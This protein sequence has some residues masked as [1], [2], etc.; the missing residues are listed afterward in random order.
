VA[1][2]AARAAGAK[3]LAHFRDGVHVETKKDGTP[4]SVAD[5]ESEATL[6]AVISKAFPS[7]AIL[8]EEEGETAGSAPY[9]WIVDPIDGTRSFVHGVPLWG[10]LVGVEV[11][12][13]PVVGVIHLPA[14][15]ETV[16]AARGE[17]CNRD[18]W[19]CHVST[20][21]RV[22]DSLIVTTS[23]RAIRRAAPHY[24][25]FAERVVSERSWG[26]CYGY[27]LVA[28]GRADIALDNRLSP[29]DLAAVLP[30]VEE[31]GGRMTDWRGERTIW[32]KEVVI[33]NG[34]LHDET[35]RCLGS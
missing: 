2:D 16:S 13:D 6:R 15:G 26:D 20:T 11:R 21:A 17:G 5:R 30:V 24:A 12:G 27:A 8:G 4:V 7:H 35:L 29:W 18:G 32:S 1:E 22:E 25:A 9:R 28:T 10:V 19:P 34:L 23:P 3:A 33:T 14:L 31:A